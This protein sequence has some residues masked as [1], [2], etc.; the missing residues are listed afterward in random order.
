[1]NRFV[2][3]VVLVV[4]LCGSPALAQSVPDARMDTYRQ[5]LS[6]ANDRIVGFS[7]K[8]L[9]LQ[10]EIARLKDQLE[11]KKPGDAEGK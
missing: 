6:E 7:V 10:T 11:K 9:E 3:A 8:V 1:M 2:V 4:I 5:L